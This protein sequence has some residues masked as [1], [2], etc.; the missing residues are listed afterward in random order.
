MTP[1][2]RRSSSAPSRALRA[3]E[4][5]RT[6]LAHTE[7]LPQLAL[8]GT[9]SGIITGIVAVIFRLGME[10]PLT[11]TLPDNNSETFETL[12]VEIRILLPLAGIVVIGVLYKLFATADGSSGDEPATGV[13][14]VIARYQRHQGF[15]PTRN[16]LLQ[17]FGG[18]VAVITGHSVGREG[19]AAHL[20]AASSSQLGQLFQLPNNSIRILVGCGVASAIAASFNTPLAGVIFAMEVV[21]MEYTVAGFI[22]VILAAISGAVISRICFGDMPAFTMP[23]LT[24]VSL[25]E[26]P[27]LVLCGLVIGGFSAGM[28]TLHRWV[29]R[30]QSLP[31]WQRLL[32]AGLIA[33]IAAALVPEV[34]G[35]GYDT[36][37]LALLGQGS[38]A[39]LAT[40]ALAKLFVSTTTLALGVP[41]GSIGPT[42]VIGGCLGACLG[43]VGQLLSPAEAS[44]TGF[45]AAL[46]MG[47]MMA[48]VLNAPLAALVALLEMTYNPNFL[49]P[50]MLVIVV[51]C[52]TTRLLSRMPGLFVASLDSSTTTSP[53]AQTLNRT[54][55]VS[56]MTAAFV[57]HSRRVGS[58]AARDLLH[59]HPE[60][61]V[62]KSGDDRHVL[63]AA[64]LA[65]YL[66]TQAREG[67]EKSNQETKDK[68]RMGEGLEE[69]DLMEIP[70]ERWRLYAIDT[71]ATL[72]QAMQLLRQNNAYA[73]CVLPAGLYDEKSIAGIITLDT[74]EHYYQ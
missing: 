10:W 71:R 36:L 25:W 65:R 9:V 29:L 16:A 72:Y 12:P 4:S 3:I 48:G 69:I 59:N 53:L 27:Y 34:M 33:A 7:A 47:A 32:A 13:A 62:V 2:F 45:Y 38:V 20:G 61:I 67:T 74:I 56:A 15:M 43:V 50:A 1:I 30:L 23:P 24:L 37:E 60:W 46:G 55:V 64:D 8:L 31:L 26:L 73:A 28:L 52:L 66:D 6:R 21:L 51:S 58:R 35:I 49:L 40:V 57:E 5:F 18:I 41:G 22:P 14:H 63:R 68:G 54:G 19:P 11:Q 44:V 17:F 42:L 39:L 70:G